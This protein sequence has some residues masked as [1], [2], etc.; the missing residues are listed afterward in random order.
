ML[1][2]GG[3]D[4]I[5]VYNDA[6]IPLFAEK[7]PQIGVPVRETWPEIWDVIGPM[8]RDVLDTHQATWAEDQMFW[9]D[10]VGFVEDIYFTFSYSPILDRGGVAQGL[11]ATAVETTERIVEA[12]RRAHRGG[13]PPCARGGRRGADRARGRG[14]GPARRCGHRPPPGRRPLRPRWFVPRIGQA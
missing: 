12:R 1:V 10:R 6:F 8:M 11:L 14:D 13:P 3:A 7:H 2:C 5:Q 4:L 9:I